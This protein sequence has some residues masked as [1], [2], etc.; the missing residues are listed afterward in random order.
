[1]PRRSR[2][3]SA[4]PV[5]QTKSVLTWK[6]AIEL[7]LQAERLKGN[8]PRTIHRHE[9]VFSVSLK[10]LESLGALANPADFRPEHLAAFVTLLQERGRKPRTINLRM[11]TFRQFFAFLHAQGY[12][13]DNPAIAVPQQREPRQLPKA[14]DDK[15]VARLLETPDRTTFAGLRD[16]TIIVLVLDTGMRLGE[17]ARL[18]LE[19]LHLAEGVIHLAVHAGEGPKDNE[20]RVVYV[21]PGCKRAL[22]LYLRERGALATRRVFISRDETPLAT[23]TIQT[24]LKHYATK[25]RV[26]VSCHRLRH[27]FA[28]GYV[29]NGGDPFSLQAIL[30][31]SDMSTVRRY[32]ELWGKDVQ[33]QHGRYTAL[34]RYTK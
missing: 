12:C 17:L 25:A 28:R 8:Q 10:E 30:G 26:P 24:R 13:A 1:M 33:Q 29:L 5:S 20:E 34:K 19:D 14:L 15:Q 23:G 22:D 18:E 21:S 11:Q 32:C 3:R 9:E 6:E 16:Y 27:T 7:F 4:A 2:V 31:H